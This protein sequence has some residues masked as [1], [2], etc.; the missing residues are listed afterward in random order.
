MYIPA[1]LVCWA[2][3]ILVLA[4]VM[5]GSITPSMAQPGRSCPVGGYAITACPV[6][7]DEVIRDQI[8]SRMAG[9]VAS[10]A[11]PLRINVCGGIVTLNGQV[12][13][14]GK[15]DLANVFAWSVRGVAE[16]HNCMTVDPSDTEDLG[17]MARV[18]AALR[19]QPIDTTEIYVRVNQGVVQLSGQ[20]RTDYDRY[21][22][23]AAAQGVPG[24]TAVYNNLTVRP[25]VYDSTSW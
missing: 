17:L 19:K 16:V 1:R 24:V 12:E 25:S 5:T 20:V 4:L 22:A 14:Q 18:R 8:A 9:T 10:A 13:T 23:A 7:S 21:D 11:Y 3:P 6:V 15:W 2:A